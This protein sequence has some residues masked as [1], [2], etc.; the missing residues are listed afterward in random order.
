MKTTFFAHVLL[1]SLALCAG[2][3]APMLSH[4]IDV[5]PKTN[6]LGSALTVTLTDLN[7]LVTNAHAKQKDILL[8]VNGIELTGIV[9]IK[10]D[11]ESNTLSFQLKRNTENKDV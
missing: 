1:G 5:S 3:E 8:F 6:Q 9:P 4:V 7:I 10:R 11:F 2:T